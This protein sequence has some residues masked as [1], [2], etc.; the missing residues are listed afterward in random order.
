MSTKYRVLE[1]LKAVGTFVVFFGGIFLFIS[2]LS[3]CEP[4]Q[5]GI[6]ERYELYELA[7]KYS[8]AE[9][10]DFVQDWVEKDDF[11]TEPEDVG[12]LAAADYEFG[13]EQGYK[14]G[15]EA[16]YDRGYADG[17]SVGYNEGFENGYDSGYDAG[18]Y[19]GLDAE[20]E[21]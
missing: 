10:R 8:D 19:D 1:G 6:T 15:R 3:Q 14:A 5:K 21:P 11:F 2:L 4:K 17:Y 16:S 9:I 20:S 12:H 18:Y 13:Y 7:D